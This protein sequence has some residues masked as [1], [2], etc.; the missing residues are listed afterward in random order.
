MM[1]L[2]QQFPQAA[3]IIGDLIAKNLDWPGAEEMAERLQKMLPSA[4]QGADPEKQ[5]MKA[6]L[7]EAAAIIQAHSRGFLTRQAGKVTQAAADV[8]DALS[9]AKSNAYKFMYNSASNKAEDFAEWVVYVKF[10][11]HLGKL[12]HA[13]CC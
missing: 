10:V 13:A 3:P 2:V 8:S 12:L 5:Q 4:L 9:R 6:Q 11:R 7:A 1:L